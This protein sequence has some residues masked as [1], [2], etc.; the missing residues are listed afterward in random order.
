V[1]I[2]NIE[3]LNEV[4]GAFDQLWKVKHFTDRVISLVWDEGHCIS[5]W[6]GFQFEY[7]NAE[8]L[9]YI[10]PRNILFFVTSVTLPP[11]VLHDVK[12]ILQM[13]DNAYLFQRLND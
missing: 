5:K 10:I 4:G 13:R 7:R 11:I 9:R 8:H 12:D 6:G 1:I 2:T 3:T